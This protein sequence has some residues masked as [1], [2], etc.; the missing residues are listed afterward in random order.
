MNII[1]NGEATSIDDNLKI[2]DLLASYELKEEITI[3]EKNGEIL[4]RANYGAES[5]AEGD[6]IELINFVGGGA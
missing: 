1:L 5:I 2:S 4:K 6:K 3:V